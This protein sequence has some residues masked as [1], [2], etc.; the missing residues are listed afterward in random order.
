MFDFS[1]VTRWFDEFL[2]STLCLGDFWT[3]L[4]ECVLVGLLII[5]GY[6]VLAIILIFMERKVC[7][8]FQCRIGPVRVG[9]WGTLQVFADVL[10]MLIKEIFV[11]DKA[12]KLLYY[13]APFFCNNCFYRYVLFF[14]ME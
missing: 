1:I 13:L 4:I 12:D 5:V 11:V 2:R 9:W 7:A 14:A 10:K 6:A 8:Y 3:I